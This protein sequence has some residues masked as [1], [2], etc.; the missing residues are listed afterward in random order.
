M[1]RRA[2]D[3]WF[4]AAGIAT[5]SELL[6]RSARG[7]LRVAQHFL[8]EHGWRPNQSSY[9]FLND[10]E[11]LYVDDQERSKPGALQIGM[12][13]S[14]VTSGAFASPA[15]GAAPPAPKYFNTET[16][17]TAVVLLA[18]YVGGVIA[19][20]FRRRQLLRSNAPQA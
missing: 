8:A 6:D 5:D 1:N 2:I 19:I 10:A 14:G 13:S 9:R 16:V 15:W 17:L 7:A 12:G 18:T 4:Q 20:V 11:P 3:L